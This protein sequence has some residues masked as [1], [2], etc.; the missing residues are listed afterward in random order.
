MLKA[1]DIAREYPEE[2][3]QE[4]TELM[5]MDKDKVGQNFISWQV[6]HKNELQQ[7]YVRG[8]FE[9]DSTIIVTTFKEWVRQSFIHYLA[10]KRMEEQAH[11]EIKH[12]IG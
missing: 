7:I 2:V 12:L 5:N 1:T 9:L 4:Q 10:N 8:I 3:Y 11:E 6:A